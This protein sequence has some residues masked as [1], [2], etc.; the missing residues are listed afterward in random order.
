MIEGWWK[1]SDP[2]GPKTCGSG[3]SGESG[4]GSIP[5]TNGSVSGRPKNMWIRIRIRIWIWKTVL[6][7]CLQRVAAMC[8]DCQQ[9]QRGKVHTSS[10]QLHSTPFCTHVDRVGPLP[11][12]SE[13]HLY[14]LTAID[15]ST[16]WVEALP[17]RDMQGR[18]HRQ[19]GGTFLRDVNQQGSSW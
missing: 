13:G 12:S 2:G 15:R 17:L 3:E 8:R 10:Q 16:R 9:C 7:C 11:A 5:L 14:L 19:L 4:F 18:F 1:N 6:K